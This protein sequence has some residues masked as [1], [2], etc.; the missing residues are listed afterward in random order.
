[1]KPLGDRRVNARF[2]VFGAFWGAF[3]VHEP[4]R[5]VNI[6]PNGALLDARRAVPIES[7]QSVHL[8]VDG[9]ATTVDGRVRH[10]TPVPSGGPQDRYL[11]GLEFVAPST[12]FLESVEQL[13]ASADS[14]DRA[15]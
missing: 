2:E 5:L 13:V 14:P 4:V 3:G 6:T 8:T 10:L 11:I 1:M 7:V 12:P 15:D 9:L